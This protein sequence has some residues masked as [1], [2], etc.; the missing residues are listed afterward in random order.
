MAKQTT[1]KLAEI[2][3]NIRLKLFQSKASRFEHDFVSP[4]HFGYE[5]TWLL[6]LPD[7]N[8]LSDAPSC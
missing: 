5:A 4:S 1:Q 7:G 2:R 6:P 8:T 3:L